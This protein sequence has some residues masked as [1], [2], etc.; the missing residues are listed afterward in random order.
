MARKRVALT[1]ALC[2]LIV[3]SCS[4]SILSGTLAWA[5]KDWTT[6]VVSFLSAE[7][8][9]SERGDEIGRQFA[10]YGLASAYLAQDEYDAA[11]QRLETLSPAAPDALTASAWYQRGIAAF[12]QGR[13]AE[14]EH[15]FRKTLEIDKSAFDARIN[16]ELSRRA[17]AE[18]RAPSHQSGSPLSF[19]ETGESGA[20]EQIFT[21]IRKK[22]QERWKNQEDDSAESGIADY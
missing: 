18:Q 2:S 7:T 15:S 4:D 21:M 12:R 10:L 6:A 20:D 9:F 19:N 22:E 1:V 16:L 17:S 3:S 8:E 11:L 14:A 5:R 13:F